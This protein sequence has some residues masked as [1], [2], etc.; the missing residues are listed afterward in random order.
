MADR[1]MFVGDHADQ[2]ASGRPLEHGDIVPASAIDPKDPHD[3]R[4]LDDGAL[5]NL[6]EAREEALD[7]AP[8]AKE[9]S[10]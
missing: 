1:L 7:S 4:L 2:T 9:K 3:K 8:A 6:T 5:I 10:K